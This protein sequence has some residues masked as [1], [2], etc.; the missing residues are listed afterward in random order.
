MEASWKLGTFRGIP[1]GLHWSMALVFGLLTVSLATA[2]FPMTH[3][4]LAS[5]TYWIMAAISAV[6]FFTSIL[7]HELGHSLTAIRHGIPVKGITLF[8]FGGVAQ[9]G[10]R[11]PSAIIELKIAAAGPAVSF[12]LGGIFLLIGVLT[13]GIAWISAPATWLGTLNLILAV[14]N[15]M[16]GFP[17]DGGRILRALVWKFTGSEDRAAQ[18]AMLS[19][20]ILAFGMM[21]VGA[22]LAFTGNLSNGLWLIFLGWFLQN[23]AASESQGSRIE[24]ALRGVSVRQAMGPRETVVPSWMKLSQL[25]EDYVLSRGESYFVVMDEEIP[26]GVVTLVDLGKV[27]RERLPW[28]SAAN[29]MTPWRQLE[30][31]TPDTPL[32]D[33]LKTMDDA[34]LSTLPVMEGERVCGLLTRE[35]VLHYIRLRMSMQNR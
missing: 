20:Q 7:L 16:P 1:I 24:I 13:D 32:M 5:G 18:V 23:A 11:P 30:V 10:G 31:V 17:L 19:G 26:R 29:V 12:A 27:P 8:I 22:Y 4:G 21:G 2:F 6:L 28:E 3:E 34:R 25:V 33:A 9:I 35:E 14:F 15:L